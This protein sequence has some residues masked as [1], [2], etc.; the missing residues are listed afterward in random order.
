MTLSNE[1]RHLLQIDVERDGIVSADDIC[2]RTLDIALPA[3]EVAEMS[4]DR[5]SLLKYRRQPILQRFLLGADFLDARGE[6]ADLVAAILNLRDALGLAEPLFHGAESILRIGAG[7]VSHRRFRLALRLAQRLYAL[8]HAIEPQLQ[9][10][11]RLAL[12]HH[13]FAEPDRRRDKEKR[14][15]DD[16]RPGELGDKRLRPEYIHYR[17]RLLAVGQDQEAERQH[18]KQAADDQDIAQRKRRH[19]IILRSAVWYDRSAPCTSARDGT[20][21]HRRGTMAAAKRGQV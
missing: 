9:R 21:T 15:K 13:R 14:D 4:L 16:H 12:P 20:R 2:K 5:P 7:E 3:V 6:V 17:R 11:R 18:E 19:A 8:P 1:L 10:P